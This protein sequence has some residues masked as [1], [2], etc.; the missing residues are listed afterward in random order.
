MRGIATELDVVRPPESIYSIRPE[1]T[2]TTSRKRGE[3]FSFAYGTDSHVYK[4]WSGAQCGGKNFALNTFYET[5]S[6]VEKED[7]DFLLVGGDWAQTH[8][9]N[10]RACSVDGRYAGEGTV[11][12]LEEA[13]LRHRVSRRAH[14]RIAHSTPVMFVL[15]NHEGEAQFSR[16]EDRCY[17]HPDTMELSE[18]ARLAH[19]PEAP[20]GV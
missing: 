5:L 2:F 13:M 1:H 3:I 10:C 4:T 9:P 7:V 19:L 17:Y 12:T 18:K 14:A 8:C 11:R 16:G 15:G 6:N 20:A